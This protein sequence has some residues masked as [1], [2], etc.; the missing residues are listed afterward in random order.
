MVV[1][2]PRTA[3]IRCLDG[4]HT[5][6]LKDREV[7]AE[8]LLQTSR[9]HSFDPETD[10]DWDQPL[11]PDLFCMPPTLVSLYETPLWERLDHRRRVELS[12]HEMASILSYGIYVELLL[13]QG[14]AMHAY[15]RRVDSRHAAYALTEIADECRHSIMFGRLINKLGL[16]AVRLPAPM[17]QAGKL[18]GGLYVPVQKFAMTLVVEETLDTMQRALFPDES[19]QPVVREVTRI[20]VIEEARHIRYAREE[21][22][23]LVADL[24]PTRRRAY[25][26]SLTPA[27]AELS[28]ALIHPSCYRAVGLD[29]AVARRV[30]LKSPHRRAT[31]AWAF[32]RTLGFFDEIGL[33]DGPARAIWHRTGLLT[34]P[35][36]SSRP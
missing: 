12:R 17:F 4:D 28:R 23:H 32:Q 14:L 9:R 2:A 13:M 30:A 27:A 10:L 3:V 18:A 15:R 34:S 26:L 11:D 8:R 31:M 7:V 6:E 25:A 16:R 22:K 20:H 19:I 24:S 21:L 29:P 33:L 1:A 35:S 36:R 5:L